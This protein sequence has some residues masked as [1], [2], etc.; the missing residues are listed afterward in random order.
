VVY[1]EAAFLTAFE[2]TV[3]RL[4]QNP[5][6]LRAVDPNVLKSIVFNAL[7]FAI[8]S[9]KHLGFREERESFLFHPGRPEWSDP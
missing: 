1:G 4:E 9:T 7:Q 6:K 8:L 3:Q 2:Q 5:D